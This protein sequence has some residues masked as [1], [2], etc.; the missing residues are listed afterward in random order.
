MP[1][2]LSVNISTRSPSV[3]TTRTALRLRTG[4]SAGSTTTKLRLR[5]GSIMLT[6]GISMLATGSSFS[7]STWKVTA[8]RANS[9][10]TCPV[11]RSPGRRVRIASGVSSC[12]PTV[13]RWSVSPASRTCTKNPP[14]LTAPETPSKSTASTR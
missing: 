12:A 1:G 14:V 13:C 2:S 10:A 3:T 4:R 5:N 6:P 7:S 11:L 9:K 8:P